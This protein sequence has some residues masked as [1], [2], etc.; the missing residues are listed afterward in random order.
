MTQLSEKSDRNRRVVL[1]RVTQVGHLVGAGVGA[2]GG[3][4]GTSSFVT[5]LLS[6]RL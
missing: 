3:R 5:R 6:R 4:G 1:C 2:G